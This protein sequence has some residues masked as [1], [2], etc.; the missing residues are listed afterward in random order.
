MGRGS[1]GG[2][3]Q[4]ALLG[5]ALGVVPRAGAR[6]RGAR[7]AAARAGRLARRA[8]RHG[9]LVAGSRGD[10]RDRG[11]RAHGPGLLRPRHGPGGDR[12]PARRDRRRG[13]QQVRRHRRD[14]QPEARLRE[15]VRRRRYQPRRADRGRHRPRVAAGAVGPG[16]RIPRLPG[17]PQRG[18]ALLRAH[19]LRA[20]TQRPGGRRHRGSARRG[21]GG[22]LGARAGLG[23]QPRAPPRSAPRRGRGRWGRQAR[24]GG[25]GGGVRPPRRLGRAA[26]RRVDRQE[27]QGHPPGRRRRPRR[28]QLRPEH[29]RLRAGQLRPRRRGEGAG[30]GLARRR[31]RTPGR[32]DA[33]LGVRHRRRRPGHRHQPVRPARRRE[34]QGG[35]AG[36]ARGRRHEPHTRV[37]RRPDHGLRQRGLAARGL[38]IGSRSSDR[39]LDGLDAEHGYVAVQAYLDRHRDAALAD[40]RDGLATRTGRPV[41][42]GWGPRFLHSTGQYHKGGP[43]TGVYVQVTGQPEADLAVPD[44]PFTFHEFLSAQAVGDGRVLAEKGRPVLRLHVSS[45]GDLDAVRQA[46]LP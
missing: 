6:H 11:R 7:R 33:A 4:A 28:S 25:R 26:R 9:R 16:G 34:R 42:F 32:A 18:R 36:D 27:R 21:R 37:R 19:G 8:V 22:A 29:A 3:G 39:L 40:V 46:L 30:L 1:R 44:R 17:R 31:R 15:G 14:R 24:A 45:P 20:G 35:R 38:F 43:P 23:G 5:D 12:G 13:V 41:T 2:S 10:L